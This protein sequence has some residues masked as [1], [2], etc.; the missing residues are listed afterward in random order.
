MPPRRPERCKKQKP[1][2]RRHRGPISFLMSDGTGGLCR[3]CGATAM[4]EAGVESA[5]NALRGKSK[6][7]AGARSSGNTVQGKVKR[8]V[9]AKSSGNTVR[10]KLKRQAGKRSGLKRSTKSILVVK[11]PWLDQILDGQKVWEIRGQTTKKRGW[12]HLAQSGSGKIQGRAR[13]VDCVA[14]SKENTFA[15]TVA[16]HGVEDLKMV[17]YDNLFAWVLQD[18]KRFRKPFS[19][20]HHTGAITWVRL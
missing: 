6:R 13:L 19:Y 4:R 7:T 3:A 2:E 11:G 12:I 20:E 1:G 17:P 18:A 5:G 15:K 8:R 16:K 9:G 14:I 10:G